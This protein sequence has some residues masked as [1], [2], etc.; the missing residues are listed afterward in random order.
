MINPRPLFRFWMWDFHNQRFPGRRKYPLLAVTERAI[1]Y[2]FVGTQNSVLFTIVVEVGCIFEADTRS[3][4][5]GLNPAMSELCHQRQMFLRAAEQSV[6]LTLFN[7]P[8][9]PAIQSIEGI[10]GMP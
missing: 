5:I 7:E 6:F 4:L 9:S 8:G 3:N 2:D 10:Y 1:R